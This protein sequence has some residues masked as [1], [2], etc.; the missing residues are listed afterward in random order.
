MDD[1]PSARPSLQ[2]DGA[3]VQKSRPVIEMK[4]RDSNVSRDLNLKVNGMQ[5]HV[6]TP[7]SSSA[8]APEDLLKCSLKFLASVG[9][10]GRIARK[11]DRRVICKK[12]SKLVPVEVV[13][14]RDEVRKDLAHFDF[15]G[16]R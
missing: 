7:R 6:W 12:T 15:I 16:L 10:M 14:C 13:E 8:N 9:A 11:E 1:L 2:N 5:V 4:S 3:P